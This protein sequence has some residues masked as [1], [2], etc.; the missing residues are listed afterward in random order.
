M[1]D[2]WYVARNKTRLGPFS[3]THIE[4][5]V[6]QNKLLPTDLLWHESFGDE[7]RSF[8]VCK[9]LFCV[10]NSKMFYNKNASGKKFIGSGTYWVGGVILVI[11]LSASFAKTKP[12][13]FTNFAPITVNEIKYFGSN[14]A[15]NEYVLDCHFLGIADLTSR[16]HFGENDSLMCISVVDKNGNFFANV[17]VDKVKDGRL[18]TNM[19][20]YKQL[21]LKGR[22]QKIAGP[23]NTSDYFFNTTNFV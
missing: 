16:L 10:N 5:Q 1:N 15:G 20:R 11:I 3:K 14:H 6:K 12:N 9:H 23:F 8:A 18:F 19:A 7:W 13:E 2:N 22:V 4:N 17:I 21:R